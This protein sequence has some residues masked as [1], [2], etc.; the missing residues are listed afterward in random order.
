VADLETVKEWAKW[1]E[2]HPESPLP[3]AFAD[4]L[5][6]ISRP[7]IREWL[8]GEAFSLKKPETLWAIAEA[9]VVLICPEAVPALVA[10]YDRWS[11]HRDG[12]SVA[13]AA[14]RALGAIGGEEADAILGRAAAHE[15]AVVRRAAASAVPLQEP[16][17]EELRGAIRRLVRD[18]H[19]AVRRALYTAL[20]EA[21][22]EDF[23]PPLIEALEN[24][25]RLRNRHV[26]YLALKAIT[27]QDFSYDSATWRQWYKDRK[28]GGL[29]PRTYTY[30]RYYG[31]GVHTD[32]V[33][34]VVDVSGSMRWSYHKRPKRIEVARRE[35]A[36]VIREIPP[37]SLFNVIV[38]A[39]KV[40]CWQKSEV[41]ATR[42]NVAKALRWSERMLAEPEG[43]TYAYDALERTF[44]NNPRFDT[45]FFLSDGWPSHGEYI[46]TEGI[47]A[48]VKSFNRDRDAVLHSIA[49]T[50]ENVDR[51]HP[52]SSTARL[53]EMKKFLQRLAAAT[54]GEC[55][56]IENAPP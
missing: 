47:I 11:E 27:G 30:A 7:E 49:L 32:R 53:R 46:S 16:L 56:S 13:A 41:E 4:G 34:F 43:D 19:E 20:G 33:V 54:G 14:V 31:F 2:K 1:M 52:Q 23:L 48:A 8:A 40:R 6:K 45:I 18:D 36:R 44:T 38:Y 50:L 25:P 24:D 28:A 12:G 22:L 51:G 37:K 39:T 9:Q 17:T 5:S 42:G 35:L 15:E 21:K 10:L 3:Q 55:K 26:A 29:K